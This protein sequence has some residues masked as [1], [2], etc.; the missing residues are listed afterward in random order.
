M[1][2]VNPVTLGAFSDDPRGRSQGQ[3]RGR[4]G[5]ENRVNFGTD[6]EVNLEAALGR[7]RAALWGI[8][9]HP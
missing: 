2:G 9:E 8:L 5:G 7:T 6:P 4:S 1:L 3:I